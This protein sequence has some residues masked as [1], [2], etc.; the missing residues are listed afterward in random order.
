[1]VP[2]LGLPAAMLSSFSISSFFLPQAQEF[3]PLSLLEWTYLR[4]ALYRIFC[5]EVLNSLFKR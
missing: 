1:M 4:F 3:S 2:F 5:F